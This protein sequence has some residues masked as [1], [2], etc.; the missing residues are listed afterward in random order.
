MAV[1]S[2]KQKNVKLSRVL[3][4]LVAAKF[5]HPCPKVMAE[6]KAMKEKANAR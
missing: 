1:S 5:N 4:W 6:Y 2:A 3:Y